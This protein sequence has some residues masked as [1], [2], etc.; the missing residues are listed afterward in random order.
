MI[1]CLIGYF[2]P[3]TMARQLLIKPENFDGFETADWR[4]FR[5]NYIGSSTEFIRPRFEITDK[6]PI[7]GNYS[8]AWSGGEQEHEWLML[9][10]AFYLARPFS[11]SVLFRAENQS[12]SWQAGLYLMQ[13]YSFFSGIQIHSDAAALHIDAKEWDAENQEDL[14]LKADTVYELLVSLDSRN[15]ITAAIIDQLSGDRLFEQSGISAVNPE[16]IA[17]YVKTEADS[18]SRLYFDDVTVESGDYYV[19]SGVWTRAPQPWFVALPRLPDVTQEEGNWVGG[20]SVMKTEEGDYLMWYRIRDNV[21]RGKGYGFARSSDGVNWV[22]HENNPV[23]V[24][25]NRYASNEK[26][27][28]LNIDGVFRGWYTVERDGLWITKHIESLDGINW[29]NDMPVI[30]DVMCKDADVIYLNG[31]YFLYCIGPNNTD[32]SVYTSGNGLEWVLREVYE[33]GTHRHL[34]VYYE[35]ENSLFA[36]YPTAGAKGVSYAVSVDGIQFEPFVQTWS[37][38]PV[39]LDD[40]T[41]AGITYL[42]FLRN[43]HGHI[44][45]EKNL[46]VYYQARNTYNNNIPGWLYH[47]GERVVLA[48]KFEGLYLNLPTRVMPSGSYQYS[49]FPFDSELVNGFSVFSDRISDLLIK[50][51]E[52]DMD[53]SVTGLLTSQSRTLIQFKIEN[54]D[55]GK[56]YIL[57]LSGDIQANSVVQDNGELILRTII[58]QDGEYNFYIRR[59]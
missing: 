3:E 7:S 15:R 27:T 34:A 40:W 20:H 33:M 36:L 6:A 17:L 29:T 22:K 50:S 8:L 24:P 47:G 37:P 45:S 32:I 14:S 49:A 46:P 10:N 18:H 39:G 35:R 26:I 28:V 2:S 51:W 4:K 1:G 23:F 44:Q 48:G 11:V 53:P 54:L 30:D 59:N 38:P 25:D 52:S 19:E 56:E 16:A 41:E 9:S 43:E 42:S 55:P 12:D 31:E 13:D 21:Q 57:E 5:P 58:P